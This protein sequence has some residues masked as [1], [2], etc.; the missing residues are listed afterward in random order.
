VVGALNMATLR[1]RFT[2]DQLTAGC[3][4]V[5]GAA[6]IAVSFSRVMPLTLAA[7]FVN[8]AAWMLTT[9]AYNIEVQL[10]APRWVAGRTLAV[11]QAAISAGIAAGGIL[12]GEIAQ[13]QGVAIALLVAG[14]AMLASPLLGLVLRMPTAGEAAED[15]R[16]Q[17]ADPDVALALTPRS[18]PIVIE[19]DY[20]VERSQA[21]AFYAAAVDV[22]RV[23]QRN[24][25]YGW[26]ISRDIANP[27][28]WTE[29]YHCPTWHDY[30]RQRSRAT[31]AER[32]LQ[33]AMGAFHRG[34]S[35]PRI[36]RLLERPFGS[37][38]WREDTPDVAADPAAALPTPGAP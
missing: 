1:A 33:D 13:G 37:V 20:Q 27:Q 36:R 4:L 24:G 28:L 30:L 11:F 14:L 5:M 32:Q 18:G 17:P 10:A 26:S 8:G 7:L 19:I 38:R 21:R 34:E 29:R 31:Q 12:W 9:A 25:A 16:D 6:T 3:M 22:Q 35:P 23:R 2:S 15:A